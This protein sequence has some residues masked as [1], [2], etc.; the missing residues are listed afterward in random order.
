MIP[1]EKFL[2]YKQINEAVYSFARTIPFK[3][4]SEAESWP[5]QNK[6]AKK[7]INEMVRP[8]LTGEKSYTNEL[9]ISLNMIL[10]EIK[11]ENHESIQE[12]FKDTF[13]PIIEELEKESGK[14]D[15]AVEKKKVGRKKK[16]KQTDQFYEKAINE[17]G[18]NAKPGEII[19]FIQKEYAEINLHPDESTIRGHLGWK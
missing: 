4:L 13:I 19:T 1:P 6:W 11:R 14:K 17:L 3:G 10:P 18:E 16:Y 9:A 2:L 8:I 7:V 12:R 5:R 15:K